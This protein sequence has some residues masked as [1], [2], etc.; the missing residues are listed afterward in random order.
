MRAQQMGDA[1]RKLPRMC[2]IAA[3]ACFGALLITAIWTPHWFKFYWL[4]AAMSTDPRVI[5][6]WCL[7]GAACAPPLYLWLRLRRLPAPGRCQRCGYDL[8]GNVSGICPECGA[9]IPDNSR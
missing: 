6:F 5:M 7:V 2:W 3:G 4:R 9:G 8:T 1:A